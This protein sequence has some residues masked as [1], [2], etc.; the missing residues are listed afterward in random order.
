MSEEHK[1][2]HDIPQKKKNMLRKILLF[3]TA[4]LFCAAMV[5]F[6]YPAEIQVHTGIDAETLQIIVPCLLIVALCDLILALF[7]FHSRD[8]V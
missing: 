1:D 2:L 7:V 4:M 6:L 3:S 8:R 5:L